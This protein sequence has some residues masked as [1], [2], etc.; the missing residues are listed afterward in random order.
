MEVEVFRQLGSVMATGYEG[1]D[2]A[3]LEDVI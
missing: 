1:K 2:E 3:I